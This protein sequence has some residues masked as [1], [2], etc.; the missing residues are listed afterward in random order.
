MLAGLLR[1]ISKAAG[2]A[3]LASILGGYPKE[4]IMEGGMRVDES[5]AWANGKEVREI[6][7]LS[8]SLETGSYDRYQTLQTR[9][10]DR[11]YLAVFKSLAAEEKRHLELLTELFE[12]HL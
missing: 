6:L 10:N 12:K 3:N 7:E 1:R 4:K 8:I 11:N 5:V 2:E 9:V